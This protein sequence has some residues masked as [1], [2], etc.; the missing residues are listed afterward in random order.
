MEKSTEVFCGACGKKFKSDAEYLKHICSKTGF[1]PTDVEH[2][3]ALSNG[4]FSKQSDAA[5]ARG[6]ARK[7]KAYPIS[8]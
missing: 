4:R 2:F 7:M 8:K 5:L 6:G 3:D 1:T